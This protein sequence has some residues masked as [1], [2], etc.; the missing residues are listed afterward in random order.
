VVITTESKSV[1]LALRRFETY[2]ITRLFLSEQLGV[3]SWMT[4]SDL[5]AIRLG[6]RGYSESKSVS[7]RAGSKPAGNMFVVWLPRI[8]ILTG[9]SKVVT[10]TESKSVSLCQCRLE[11]CR[12]RGSFSI[13]T[14]LDNHSWMLSSDAHLNQLALSNWLSER[15]QNLYPLACGG[16]KPAERRVFFSIG[17]PYDI[18]SWMVSSQV[19]LTVLS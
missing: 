17:I 8:L 14:H 16:S 1:S 18:Y 7:L 6:K 2:R 10:T 15:N 19:H 5:H 4:P 3:D 13:G 11:T 9:L 12:T